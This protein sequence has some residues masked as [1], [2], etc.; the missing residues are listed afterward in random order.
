[1]RGSIT[2]SPSPPPSLF[3]N[4]YNFLQAELPT[5]YLRQEFTSY[6]VYNPETGERFQP[7]SEPLIEPWSFVY[8]TRLPPIL[9]TEDGAYAMGAYTIEDFTAYEIL[10]YD[11]PNPEDRTN[12]WNIVLH[13]QPFPAGEHTYTSFVV[14]GTLEGVMEA[15]DELFRIHPT[16]FNPPEGYIDQAT[17]DAIDGWGW[18]PKTPDEPIDIEARLVNEDGSENFLAEVPADQFR[19]DLATALGDNGRHGFRL[20]GA[21]FIPD[22]EPHRYRFYALNSNPGLPPRALFPEEVDLTCPQFAS[23]ATPLPTEP[24]PGTATL[25]PVE[26]PSPTSPAPASSPPATPVND[27]SPVPCL[28]GALPLLFSVPLLLVRRRKQRY[29]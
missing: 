24:P 26:E 10:Y 17:C 19:S 23:T 3:Q 13:E 9:A 14:V 11:I 16:D 12:K 25:P 27:G 20:A 4:S 18:D 22:G 2:S 21:A 7:E 28:G 6:W 29:R 5:G 15:M 1:M 8:S